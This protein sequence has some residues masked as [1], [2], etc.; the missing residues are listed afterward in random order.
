M[1]GSATRS[2]GLAAQAARAG[3]P[4]QLDVTIVGQLAQQLWMLVEHDG[5]LSVSGLLDGDCGRSP[6][7]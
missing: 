1:S 6:D 5:A 4:L 3:C 7:C 2:S